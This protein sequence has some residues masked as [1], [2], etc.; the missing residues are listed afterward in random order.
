MTQTEHIAILATIYHVNVT[1]KK[2]TT[3]RAFE[4]SRTIRIAP[5]RGDVSYAIALHELGHLVEPQ[6]TGR[7]PRLL[8]EWRAWQ[9]AMRN[10]TQWS[11]RMEH[12]RRKCLRAYLTR[13]HRHHWP[14]PSELRGLDRAR[15]MTTPDRT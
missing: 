4:W 11:P 1:E 14:I 5:V 12:T 9:W 7:Y 2:G 8:K 13:A 15:H 10:A 6:A 3:G